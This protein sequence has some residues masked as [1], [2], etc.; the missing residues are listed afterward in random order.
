MAANIIGLANK[1]LNRKLWLEFPEL[2]ECV[3]KDYV[4]AGALWGG[5]HSFLHALMV[6]Q[7]AWIIA[8]DEKTGRLAWVAGLC[9]DINRHFPKKVDKKLQTY[10]SFTKF[11]DKDKHSI[12][13]AIKKHSKIN[14]PGD[15]PVTLTLKDADRLANIGPSHWVRD[16]QFRPR[17]PFV[18]PIQWLNDPKANFKYPGSVIKCVWYTLEWE[19]WLRLPEAKKI[20]KPYFAATRWFLK[21]TKKQLEEVKL[22]PLPKELR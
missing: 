18:D 16:G 5:A 7:Y 19:S 15:G 1:G 13:E 10:L 12:I 8:E 20:A 21:T 11:S 22:F 17:A 9:H 4:R 2:I 14:N 6:A 3:K